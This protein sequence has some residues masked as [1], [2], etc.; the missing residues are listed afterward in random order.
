M[1][2]VDLSGSAWNAN[3]FEVCFSAN[4]LYSTMWNGALQ[5]NMA[6][7]EDCMAL[8]LIC[9]MRARSKSTSFKDVA[10]IL[11]LGEMFRMGV[12]TQASADDV[13]TQLAALITSTLSNQNGMIDGT[14]NALTAVAEDATLADLVANVKRVGASRYIFG[15]ISCAT[16]ALLSYAKKGSITPEFA[17]SFTA[18]IKTNIGQ[19]VVLEPD[20]VRGFFDAFGSRINAENAEAFAR[21]V[22]EFIPP[23]CQ[24]L[25]TLIAQMAHTGMTSCLTISSAMTKCSQFEWGKVAKLF[26]A[27]MEAVTTAI[28]QVKANPYIGYTNSIGTFASSHYRNLAWV[29]KELLIRACGE[30]G[31]KNYAGWMRRPAQYEKLQELIDKYLVEEANRAV[32]PDQGA[33]DRAM[34]AIHSDVPNRN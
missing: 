9:I 27:E 7:R 2:A 19:S 10:R 34:A 13:K 33:V 20:V 31:L 18:K 32:E 5:L 29:S 14:D 23:S 26:P 28:L 21:T 17:D 12:V 22:G 8:G 11:H 25:I 16:L 15:Q 24:P 4:E 1:A 6:D 30:T 3:F